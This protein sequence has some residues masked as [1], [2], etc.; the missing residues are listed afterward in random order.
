MNTDVRARKRRNI[1]VDVNTRFLRAVN[2][3]LVL[4]FVS[5][6]GKNYSATKTVLVFPDQDERTGLL[7]DVLKKLQL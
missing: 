6:Q 5:L 4:L 1:N 2:L 7:V 3:Q